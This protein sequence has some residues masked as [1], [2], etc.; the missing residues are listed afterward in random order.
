MR[1][2]LAFAVLLVVLSCQAA[3]AE[4]L[5][6]ATTTSTQDTGLLDVVAPA[7]KKDTG[8]D[9][10]WV[11]VGTGKALE[12]GKNCDADV[13]LV[14]APSAEEQYVAAGYAIRR[15]QF[16]YNDFVLVGPPADPAG[17]R[18]KSV[19][20]ALAAIAVQKAPFVSRGDE[21][22]THKAEKE[23]WQTAGL[24][25]PGAAAGQ[26]AWYI[27]SGQGMM[28]TLTMAFEKKAYTLADRGT[29][30]KFAASDRGQGLAVLLEGDPHLRNVYAAMMVNPDKCPSVKTE[31]AEKFVA[32]WSSPGAEALIR[33]FK[34]EGK[35]LF[36]LLSDEK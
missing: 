27:Q 33:G 13:L 9:L 34:L 20:E 35:P 17:I 25:V 6:L 3:R 18:G 23:L 7:F 30:I 8:I 2:T 14:H 22:G 16:M 1:Q 36:F 21:S 26:D 24:A 32:W 5:T 15:H 29:Y 4:T 10:K 11:A 12:L 19:A 28:A 31:A